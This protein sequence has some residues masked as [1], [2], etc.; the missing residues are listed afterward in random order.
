MKTILLI[1][2]LLFST[3][4][5]A[6]LKAGELELMNGKKIEIYHK[7]L[8]EGGIE[9]ASM[10][11]QRIYYFNI[12]GKY[13]Q[14]NHSKVSTMII[15]DEKY[16]RLPI[17]VLSAK[18]LHRI[19]AEN[20][21]YILTSYYSINKHYFYIFEKSTMDAVEKLRSHDMEGVETIRQYFG[22]CTE[23]MNKMELNLN[24][25][26]ELKEEME[27]NWATLGSV[28]FYKINQIKCE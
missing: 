10:N 3:N 27:Y 17:Y 2:V 9:N 21:K 24:P 15:G 1:T 5:Y 13:R 11:G 19:I 23:L 8:K 7:I 16:V 4:N 6:Q 18:R 22:D 20:N 25:D 28:L 12:K 26:Q 14:I